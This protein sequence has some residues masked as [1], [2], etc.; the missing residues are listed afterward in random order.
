M[1]SE[2]CTVKV[3]DADFGFTGSRSL[4]WMVISYCVVVSKSSV[5]NKITSQ[6]SA[7]K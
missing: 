5:S 4:A 2:T 7:S 1:I 3:A 6:E